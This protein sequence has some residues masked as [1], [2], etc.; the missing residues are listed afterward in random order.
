MAWP[1]IIAN[2]FWNLQLTVDRIFLGQYSTEALAAAM[3]V[4][5]IFWTPMAL[6][7]QTAAYLTTFVAQYFGAKEPKMIGP[8]F[9]QSVY[10]SVIGGL[11]FLFFIPI[12]SDFFQFVGHSESVQR[13]EVE[14]FVA[15]CYSALP[16]ALVAA[17]SSFFSGLGNT[18]TV[19]WINFV[20]LVANVI[21]D[22]IMI[23]GKFGFPAMGVAGAGYA[24][25]LA[26]WCSVF[27]ALYLVFQKKNE[28][29]Y[30][31]RSAWRFLSR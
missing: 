29:E 16:A 19:L 25:A 24:T 15:I 23:F 30:S 8:A 13:L 12:T 26:N 20:G 21:F 3:T 27:F 17:A 22:Y 14:Y 2:S 1:L 31:M 6:L 28:A 10:V 4:M 9:W 18:Q 5:G 11:L 7:Q